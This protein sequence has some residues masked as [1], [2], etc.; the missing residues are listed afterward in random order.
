MVD[1]SGRYS[2]DDDPKHL[3]FALARYKFAA[4]MLCGQGRV[5]EVGCGDGWKSR[6]VAQQVG[7]LTAFDFDPQLIAAAKS[8]PSSWPV[9]FECRDALN[10]HYGDFDAVYCIDFIEHIAPGSESALLERLHKSAP[11]CII[12]T[13]SIESQIHASEVSKKYHVNCKSGEELRR[14]CL[15]RWRQVFMFG[16]NDETVHTGFLPM[17]HYLFAVCVR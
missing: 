17:A 6:V 1:R 3:I 8:A 14:L 10:E 16:M 9:H 5:L 11:V 13:P 12:G 4:K 2:Y 7:H 15:G